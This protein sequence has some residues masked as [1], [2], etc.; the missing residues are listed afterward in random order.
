MRKLKIATWNVRGM[1]DTMDRGKRGRITSWV[2]DQRVNVLLLQE[3]KLSE[4]KL[5]ELEKWW[6]GPQVW[7]P[8]QG[9]RGGVG[10]LIHR[11][12]SVKILDSEAD[13]WGRWAWVRLEEGR[14]E[15]AIMSVYA[16]T[17]PKERARFFQN[18]IP[19]IPK[20]EKLI[21]A[22]DWNLSLDTA[23]GHA[24]STT[25]REDTQALLTMID[26]LNL[27]DPFRSLMPEAAGYTWTSH[28]KKESNLVTRRRLDYFLVSEQVLEG[29]TKVTPVSHPLSYHKPVTAEINLQWGVARGRGFFR[30]N[31][32]N[33]ADAG[34]MEWVANHMEKWETAKNLFDST[35]EWF[36]GGT[37][38]IS[39]V[40]EV[41]SKIL[42]KKRNQREAECKRRVEEAEERMD[43]HPISARVWAAER[44][45]KMDEWDKVQMEDQAWRVEILREKGIETNDKMNKETF[46]R[47]LPR[48]AQQ[49]MTELQ[50]P[51]IETEPR[52]VTAQGML[53]YANLYYE[54]ILSPRQPQISADSDLTEESDLWNYT[55]VKIFNTGRLDMERPLTLEEVT[56]TV[57][58]MAKGKSPGV[59]GL[60]VEFYQKNW[61]CFGQAL[62]DVY[63]GVLT[64]GKLGKRMTHGVIAMLFK[65]GDKSVIKNWRP[66]SLLNVSYKILAKSLA[67]RLA[68]YLPDLVEEDQGAFVQGR[69]IF[70][71]IITAVEVLEIV[72]E[73]NLDMGVLLL[74]LEKAYDKVGW[75]FVLT[76]LRHMGFGE[77]TC[78]WVKAMYTEATSAVMING[79]M[80]EAFHITRSLTPLLFVLQMEVLLNRVR[81]HPQIRGL[82]LA[83][84]LECRVKALADDLFM[85]CENSAPALTTLR[86]VMREHS[87]LSEASINWGKSSYFLPSC[88]QLK[89]EWGMARVEEGEKE[90]FLGVLISLQVRSTTQ[91]VVL[92]QRIAA[93]LHMWGIT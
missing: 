49:Q 67:R 89:A 81:S 24:S 59:D 54:D 66:I 5:V 37:T 10:I 9:T 13:I 22:G 65:S 80:S 63:N 82:R 12:L 46:Q 20:V 21:M 77:N 75:P 78:K 6:D 7:A 52:A 15:C 18:L 55:R 62:V 44:V 58:S 33:L 27:V 73:E 47:L 83:S 31:N 32:Q 30:L 19:R 64:G 8:A 38:I 79:H 14:M 88:F 2:H 11:D 29:V 41:C 91:G 17:N 93:R 86:D 72:Q 4:E 16:P 39:S 53:K 76:S 28:M 48:R 61:S 56:Q 35:A 34:L 69:S 25:N 57:G 51:F 40:L 70:N 50:H 84:G 45:R 92:Q 71:N 87:R 36:D 60:T 42:A 26:E 43:G 74:D 23:L 90:R 85:I 1:E 68:R 3:T